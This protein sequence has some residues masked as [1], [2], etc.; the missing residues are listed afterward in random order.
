MHEQQATSP[1]RIRI[2]W[3]VDGASG[4]GDWFPENYR[5]SLDRLVSGLNESHGEGTHRVVSEAR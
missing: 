2:E 3:K 1:V 4:H 5:P